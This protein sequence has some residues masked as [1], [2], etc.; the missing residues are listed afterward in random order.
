MLVGL[1]TK[2][3]RAS[4]RFAPDQHR[5]LQRPHPRGQSPGGCSPP[6]PWSRLL[7]G[8]PPAL[9]SISPLLLGFARPPHNRCPAPA[10]PATSPQSHRKNPS[11]RTFISATPLLQHRARLP[12]LF[13]VK[14]CIAPCP[15]SHLRRSCC[16]SGLRVGPRAW[17]PG[18]LL[19]R[20]GAGPQF[21]AGSG[22]QR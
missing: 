8:K 3:P 21:S 17:A 11:E 16:L 18:P 22:S 15:G 19:P 6:P 9:S 2:A 4:L 10:A 12:A 5:R 14:S 1:K 7:Q 20:G 13:T